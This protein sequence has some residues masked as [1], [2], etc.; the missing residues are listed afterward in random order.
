MTLHVM[1]NAKS[2]MTLQILNNNAKSP[3]TLHILIDLMGIYH[4]DAYV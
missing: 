2:P 3:M 1:N 4:E